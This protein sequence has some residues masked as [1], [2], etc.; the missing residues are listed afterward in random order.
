MEKIAIGK[1]IKNRMK[2]LRIGPAHLSR[3][4]DVH[5]STVFKWFDGKSIPKG[6]NLTKLADLLKT[7]QDYIMTGKKPLELNSQ[8][9]EIVKLKSRIEELEK[10]NI[11]I[12]EYEETA[13]FYMKSAEAKAE[14]L[15]K[16]LEIKKVEYNE[17]ITT[18][19]GRN[20]Q[21]D[22]D[23]SGKKKRSL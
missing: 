18:F 13:R 5:A 22:P 1:R 20:R 17:L 4:I 10:D 6:S 12:R 7:S 8:A 2:E 3:K 16:E 19:W 14:K 21:G 11:K 23:D 9:D 15:E